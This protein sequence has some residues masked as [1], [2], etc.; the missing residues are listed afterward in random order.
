MDDKESKEREEAEASGFKVTDRRM[1][2]PDGELRTKDQAK[3]EEEEKES[4]RQER[5]EKSE[6]QREK[7]QAEQTERLGPDRKAPD[8]NAETRPGED[9]GREPGP[10]GY[11]AGPDE[12]DF[13]SFV[14]SLATNAMIFLGEIADPATGKSVENLEAGRQL[15]D[16]L[17]MLKKKTEG[18]RTPEETQLLD[19]I[20]YELRMKF[21]SKNKVVDL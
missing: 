21:L 15:I 4:T 7:A 5:E 1:F 2:T 8:V 13:P 18:N 3:E 17:G 19:N 20:L 16:I 10:T 9:M 11:Q 12:V 14:A 6:P